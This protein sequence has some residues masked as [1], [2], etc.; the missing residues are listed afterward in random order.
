MNRSESI[1][2]ISSALMI[3]HQEVGTIDRN[4]KG[5]NYRYASLENVLDSIRD[6]LAKAG[7]I[8]SQ[9]PTDDYALTTILMHPESGEFFETTSLIKPKVDDPQG[10]G[11]SITY[12]RRY[13]LVAILGLIV[14]DDDASSASGKSHS[15]NNK[16]AT[17]EKPWLNEKD[18]IFKIAVEKLKSGETTVEK[19]SQSYNLSKV[20]KEKLQSYVTNE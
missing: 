18:D 15:T 2:N 12:N 14:E 5:Y 3:F 4:S 17:A 7:L 13:H 6:P 20:V 16:N 8:F 19:I 10:R 1:K 9:F 11:S